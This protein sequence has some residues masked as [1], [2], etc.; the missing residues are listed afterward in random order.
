MDDVA[1]APV[2]SEPASAA[3]AAGATTGI[4]MVAAS[5]A[6]AGRPYLAAVRPHVRRGFGA[7]EPDSAEM[8][9]GCGGKRDAGRECSFK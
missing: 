9:I 3:P 5:D 4:I 6:A 1:P 2:A 8:G 7:K